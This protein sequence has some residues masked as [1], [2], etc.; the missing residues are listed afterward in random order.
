MLSETLFHQFSWSIARYTFQCI[1]FLKSR[2]KVLISRTTRVKNHP[3]LSPKNGTLSPRLENNKT[4][5]CVSDNFPGMLTN[6]LF[7]ENCWSNISMYHCFPIQ[8]TMSKLRL[9]FHVVRN[10]ECDICMRGGNN[11]YV[12]GGHLL[13]LLNLMF[14]VYKFILDFQ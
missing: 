9:K 6:T 5:K 7:L 2:D 8:G 13:D 14:C 4:L 1:I 10:S 12:N 3:V 11:I